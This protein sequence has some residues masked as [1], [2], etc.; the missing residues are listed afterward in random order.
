MDDD[1]Q[2]NWKVGKWHHKKI[3]VI[4]C[5]EN[6]ELHNSKLIKNIKK[7]IKHGGFHGGSKERFD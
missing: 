1:Q 3:K 4:F 5:A 7:I 2:D 6:L